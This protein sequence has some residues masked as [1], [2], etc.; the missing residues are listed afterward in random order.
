[1]QH[2]VNVLWYSTCSS[3]NQLFYLSI[4]N[5]NYRVR[6]FSVFHIK[7]LNDQYSQRRHQFHKRY[8]CFCCLESFVF[9]SNWKYQMTKSNP[10]FTFS[11]LTFP[12]YTWII[13]KRHGE[14]SHFRTCIYGVIDKNSEWE[15]QESI[16]N[17]I[18]VCYFHLCPT[19]HGKQM[20]LSPHSACVEYQNRLGPIILVGDQST[21]KRNDI[22]LRETHLPSHLMNR[23]RHACITYGTQL[24]D[25][26]A[27]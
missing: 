27:S 15:I 10:F 4:I 3:F 8:I 21:A 25:R 16:S 9:F 17:S 18:R 19:T 14:R 26:Y 24:T 12:V 6:N 2:L 5:G 1:M 23:K 11:L 7:F 22:L 13:Q 20:R